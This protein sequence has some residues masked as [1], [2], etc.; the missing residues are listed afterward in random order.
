MKKLFTLVAVALLAAG[1]LSAQTMV[2]KIEGKEVKNGDDVVISKP[3]KETVL[4]PVLKL[5]DLGVEVEFKTLVDQ[6]VQ[7]EGV[8]LEQV[9]PGLA[10]CPAG[11][12]CTTANATNSWTSTASLKN[13]AANR[14][15]NGEWIHYEYATT[16]PAEGVV[17]KSKITFKGDSE[18]ITFNLTINNT[19]AGI[20]E[21]V[22]DEAENAVIYNISGQQVGNDAKG[23][24]VKNGKKYLKK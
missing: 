18:T 24:V 23:I 12:T 4:N 9:S 11:F 8:D 13:L 16:K 5:Y 17:R 10:C 1:S 2:I 3:A 22:A 20:N 7:V 14:E 15:V 21:I 6:T 19:T